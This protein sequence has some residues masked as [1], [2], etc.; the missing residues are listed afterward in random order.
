MCGWGWG[1]HSADGHTCFAPVDSWT[2]GEELAAY[3]LE[4]ELW[5]GDG[6]RVSVGEQS[7]FGE[8]VVGGC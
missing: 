2:T 8:L 4:S 1:S 5:V 3:V 6:V 7:R